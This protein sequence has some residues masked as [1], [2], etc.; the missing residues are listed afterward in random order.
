MK[1]KSASERSH[2]LCICSQYDKDEKTCYVKVHAPWEVLTRHAEIMNL[3]MPLAKNDMLEEVNG[4]WS[5]CPTPFDYDEAILPEIPDYFTAP[6]S[7]DREKQFIIHDRSTFFSPAQRSLLTHQIL[8][9]AI[10][11]DV[12]DPAK[13]RFGLKKM[14]GVGAYNAAFPLHEG[15]YKSEHSIM[16]SGAE[17]Q[18]HLLYE[19]WARPGAWYKF[20]P[21][22][23]IRLYFGEKIAIYFTWLGYYTALL[24]PAGI[25]GLG[26]FIYGVISYPNDRAS[27][28]ICD[29]IHAGNYTMCPLCDQQCTYWRLSRSCTYAKV[30]YM[31]DNEYTVTF[32]AFMALWAVFFNE[33]WKRRQAEIEYDWDVED[34]EEEE[35]VRPEYEASV[36]KRRVNPINK[37]EEPYMTFSSKC[38]RFTSSLWVV[39]F[40]LCVVLAAVF[41]VIV[42]RMT[43]SS[44]LYAV[45]QETV[46]TRA[47]TIT[48]LTGA[49]INLTVIIILGYIYQILAEWLT[50]FETHRTLTEWEDSFTLKMFL[51]QFVNHYAS[52]FYI[53]FLKGKFVGR[54]GAYDRSIGGE[55][56]E[57]CDPSGCLIELCIQLAVIM[58]GKQAFNNFKELALPKVMNWFNAR[59]VREAE[60]KNQEKITRWEKDYT[61]ATI[62]NLGLFDEYLEMVLQYGFVTIFVA[63]FP[64]APICA[65]INNIIEIR[66]DA[67]KFTTQWRR[68]LAYRAQDIGIWWFILRGITR[69]AVVTNA[70]IIAFTSEFIPKLV[71]RY[72]FS[73]DESLNGYIKWSL[74]T[75]NVSEFDER[76][77]PTDPKI[78]EFGNLTEC[79]YRAYR[80]PPTGTNPYAYTVIHWQVLTAKLA[81]ILAFVI[82]VTLFGWLISYL[83]PDVPNNVK[84]QVLREKHLSKEAMLEA[85]HLRP[86]GGLASHVEAGGPRYRGT[87]NGDQPNGEPTPS[88]LY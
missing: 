39:F 64:L 19:T 50:N 2:A 5:K 7:R 78:E 60:N 84:L 73:D 1:Q 3:K 62:P 80:E 10:F 40:M 22:D 37:M 70:L 49:C 56:Q 76:S 32:A 42:Y 87:E 20:Q 54:P 8:D 12:G 79:Y 72:S 85:D 38:L 47:S 41:G 57:E 26:I 21:L 77:R 35:T 71:Y 67:Y 55:R 34:F 86:A 61:M 43:I 24:V 16:A 88:P 65:L 6:F 13:N 75:F 58:V 25:V 15:E 46:K 14:L 69:I 53:A 51:F 31:F 66:L 68:P 52:L 36:R 59:K 28:D 17:N 81:F 82:V 30:T 11:E 9:R 4:C 18:R 23:H 27:G 48:S 83:V 44:L 33:M 45:D 29:P 63:A 74:S